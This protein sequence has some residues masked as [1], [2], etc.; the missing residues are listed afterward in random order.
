M[1]TFH[2]TI[3]YEPCAHMSTLGEEEK[4]Q[5][6]QTGIWETYYP[7]LALNF[8][9]CTTPS[10]DNNTM[11]TVQPVGPLCQCDAQWVTLANRS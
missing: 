1:K 7:P 11:A 4:I 10:K 2:V 8:L 5:I 6:S 3:I 9:T